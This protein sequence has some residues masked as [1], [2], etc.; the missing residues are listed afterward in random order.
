MYQL[1]F[2]LNAMVAYCQPSPSIPVSYTSIPITSRFPRVEILENCKEFLPERII[3]LGSFATYGECME[4]VAAVGETR[5]ERAIC[6][7]AKP[8]A[9]DKAVEERPD[10]LTSCLRA[11]EAGKPCQFEILPTKVGE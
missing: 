5:R 2:I 4:R 8:A 3:P 1:V 9:I 10:Y 7:L 6:R 11:S